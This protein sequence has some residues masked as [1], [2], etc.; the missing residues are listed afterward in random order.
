MVSNLFFD[1]M[2]VQTGN[3][4]QTGL[5]SNHLLNTVDYFGLNKFNVSHVYFVCCQNARETSKGTAD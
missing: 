4:G 1:G 2:T 5:D 3:T